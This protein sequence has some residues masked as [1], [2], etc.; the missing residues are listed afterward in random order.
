MKRETRE[1]WKTE[2]TIMEDRHLHKDEGEECGGVKLYNK[3]MKIV[4]DNTLKS[5]LNLV[6]EELLPA[7]RSNLFPKEI[8]PK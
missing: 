8:V 6:F 2:L 4:C 7:I 5:R 1:D 3:N